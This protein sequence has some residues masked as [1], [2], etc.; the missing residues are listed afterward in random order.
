MIYADPS[1]SAHMTD[2]TEA[3]L[4][5]AIGVTTGLSV[6]TGQLVPYVPV[7]GVREPLSVPLGWFGDCWVGLQGQILRYQDLPKGIFTRRVGTS[8]PPRALMVDFGV[9][10]EKTT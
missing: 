8:V 9:V 3:A 1:G 4:M 10:V 2:G 7:N 5:A 6:A